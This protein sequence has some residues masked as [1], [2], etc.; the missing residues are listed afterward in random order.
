MPSLSVHG[1]RRVARR[2]AARVLGALLAS[3]AVGRA[4]AQEAPADSAR[5]VAR[6]SAR[7][8]AVLARV[9][10]TATRTGRPLLDTPVA[11]TVVEPRDFERRRAFGLDDALSF[12]PGVLAQSRYGAQDVRL[13]IRGFGA[14]GAGDRSNAGTSRGVR[15]LVDG[16]PETEPDGRTSFDQIELAAAE[17]IE[18]VRSNSGATW[19]NAAG[20]LLN[21]S[22][23]PA[24]ARGLSEAQVTMGGFGMRRVV[25]RG[26]S[27]LSADADPARV[28]AT[29]ARTDFDGWRAQS[30]AER[31]TLTAGV[32]API[33]G[34]GASGEA[35][36]TLGVHLLA[37]RNLFR[38]PGPLTAAQLAVDPSQANATYAE[39][40]ERRFNQLGRLAVTLEHRIGARADSGAERNAGVAAMLFVNP[41]YLQRSERGTYRDFNRY[42][43][44][45]NL[46]VRGGGRWLG[47]S[48]RMAAG[49]D[50]AYQDGTALFYSLAPN[51]T[52]GTTLRENKAE[53]SR[54]LGA[55]AQDELTL[56]ARLSL[57]LGARWDEVAYDYRSY[58]NPRLDA[59]K[60]FRRLSPKLGALWRAAP[61]HAVYANFGGGIEAPAGNET[62]PAP[63]SDTLLAINPLLDAIRSNSYEIGGRGSVAP[64]AGRGLVLAASYDA[65]AYFIDVR[66]EIV[67]YRGGRF[68][69]TAGSARR[70]GVELG[71]RAALQ[72][73]V[74]V[75]LSGTVARNVYGTYVVDSAYYSRP[76]ASADLSG[77]R[78]VGVP[79]AFGAVELAWA[80]PPLARWSAEGR[81][82]VQ[83]VGPYWADDANRVRVPGY[84]VANVGVSL[85][86]IPGAVGGYAVRLHLGVENLLDRRFVA[87]AFLNPDL[88]GGAPLAF[89]PGL[90]R[91]L[92]L[93]ASVGRR[94]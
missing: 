55:F 36:T 67:P 44:G 35:T 29:L 20:G 68:Y 83:G 37:S 90:P 5:R 40:D 52:R 25:L 56:G 66:N 91:Q 48:H 86:P 87:S 28:W 39:R 22:T 80:P 11:A 94:R 41:K 92:V 19:G 45:G 78:I 13:V 8:A 88:V 30:A 61:Q 93:S 70:A 23:V 16:V 27:A 26:G 51:G 65:A 1:F 18:V 71:G 17:R 21:V 57:T 15:V 47:L 79:D 64:G 50:G 49:V 81:A 72:G 74:S 43:V 82:G 4:A 73:G 32:L 7:A 62:D 85:V 69:F 42:H 54:N 89:E 53:G 58:I 34:R 9:T 77:N 60:A 38:I 63:P 3:A 24:F 75:R 10:V 12:A 6:D 14:R 59:R 76:G 33:G 31:T 2:V 84:A 46:A